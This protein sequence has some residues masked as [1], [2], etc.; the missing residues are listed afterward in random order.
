MQTKSVSVVLDDIHE[1][2]TVEVALAKIQGHLNRTVY[3]GTSALQ[4]F[5][6]VRPA[7]PSASNWSFL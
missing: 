3:F 7:S 4:I 6:P 2:Y 1:I 5:I